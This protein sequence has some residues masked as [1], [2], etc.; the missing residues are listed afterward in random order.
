MIARVNSLP[1][2]WRGALALAS[3]AGAA[4]AFAPWHLII[5][6]PVAFTTLIWLLDRTPRR[7]GAFFIGWLFGLG[8]FLVAVHWVG[9]AFLVDAERF[10]WMMPGAVAGLAAGLA[11]FPA[12]TCLTAHMARPGWPR[13]LA[14]AL[15]WS[16]AEWLRGHILTGFPWHSLGYVWTVGDAAIQAASL[17]G[18]YGLGLLTVTGAS[19]PALFVSANRPPRRHA[20]IAV[21]AAIAAIAGLWAYGSDRL[22]RTTIADQPDILIRIVQGG[23]PQADKWRRDLRDRN[24]AT[25]LSLSTQDNAGVTHVIWPETA[26]PFLLDEDA[27]RRSLIAAALPPEGLLITGTPR[28]SF[29]PD[30]KMQLFNSVAV[31]RPDGRIIGTYDKAHLVPFGEYLPLRPVLATFGLDKLAAGAI[32]YTAGSGAELIDLPGL[33]RLRPLICYEILFPGEV[34]APKRA[35]WLLNLTND[36][37]FGDSAGPK[38]HFQISRMRAVELG[39][40]VIRAAN[41][42]ISGVIDPLGRYGVTLVTGTAGYLDATLPAPLAPTVYARWG[43]LP[44]AAGC[45]LLL[46]ITL[47]AGF[48]IRRSQ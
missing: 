34:A 41:T 17:F 2:V 10:G 12:L 43:D 27:Q 28:R 14:L 24:L 11:L 25:Y 18:V 26:T 22:Q 16:A 37:W 36:A 20:I 8:F 15:A 1:L 38:Q 45:V 4:L 39:V 40:P 46:A 47:A 30:G 23:I 31:L 7:P 5:L 42:G 19:L 3:G 33:P 29:A 44:F 35:D 21:T 6:L 48:R 32:D 9:H 13:I